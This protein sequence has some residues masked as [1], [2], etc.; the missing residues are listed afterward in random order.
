M[1]APQLAHVVVPGAAATPHAVQFTDLPFV[2]DAHDDYSWSILIIRRQ[3]RKR[4]FR[5]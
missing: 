3:S 5:H 1:D 2:R 4:Q